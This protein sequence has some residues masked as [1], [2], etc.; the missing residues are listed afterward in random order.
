ML[1]VVCPNLAIDRILQVDNLTPSVVQRS[2]QAVV[3]PGG[4]GS[5]V[6]RVF[7]QLGG[8]VV[9]VG[10]VGSS[11]GRYVVEPLRRAGIHADAVEAYEETRTCTIICDSRPGSHPTVIN[12]ES[13][14]V[15][16]AAVAALLKKVERWIREADGVLTTGSLSIGA[17]AELYAGIL[18]RA[19][20]RGKTTAIDATGV[21]LRT[22]L[23]VRPT[24]MKPNTAE[25]REL[26]EASTVSLLATHTALTFGK[27]GAMVLHEG[28][29]L[30]APPPRI[31]T[32]NPVGAGDA[33]SAGYLK[34]LLERRP[35]VECL[36]LALAAAASDA[37][38]LRPGWIDVSQ[39]ATLGAEVEPRF[40]PI[41]SAQ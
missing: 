21:A 5:N 28:R 38:T 40:T 10:F 30:Y 17:P 24:F 8:D 4:K 22:G 18:D 37:G 12:E 9:L 23:L 3:Q 41:P 15:E 27:T 20:S 29:C 11:N 16:P 14:Q 1:L 2:R 34:S 39:V 13:P 32:A 35:V 19:R 7:R 6:A 25:M 31:F 26:F 36:R 33:F